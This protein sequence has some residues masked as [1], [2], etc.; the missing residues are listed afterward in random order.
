MTH[1]NS[2][3]HLKKISILFCFFFKGERIFF[4]DFKWIIVC[5][6]KNFDRNCKKF[7]LIISHNFLL[8]KMIPLIFYLF[9]FFFNFLVGMIPQLRNS[10]PNLCNFNG[11][12]FVVSRRYGCFVPLIKSIHHFAYKQFAH[13][14]FRNIAQ[15]SSDCNLYIA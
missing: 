9:V 12:N 8:C 7:P 6:D 5:G 3:S 15:F 11:T 4:I 2:K 13:S 10:V 14:I 1:K